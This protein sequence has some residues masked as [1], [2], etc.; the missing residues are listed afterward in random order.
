MSENDIEYEYEYEWDNYYC[1]PNSFVLKN[2]F[3][4]TDA[5]IL[6][7]AERRI[8][9]LNLLEMKD[10]PIRGKFDLKHLCKI[11]KAIF[12]DVFAWAG[13]L[14]TVDI[15]KGNQFCLSQN[16]EMY[17]ETVFNDLKKEEY[18]VGKT[19]EEMPERLTY[20]L[21]EIN[22]LHPFRDGNGRSQRVFIEYLARSVGY[23]VDFS[24]VTGKEMIEASALSFCKEYEMMLDM[25]KRITTKTTLQEQQM[26]RKQIGLV[27]EELER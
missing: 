22:V 25:F 24:D 9:S 12:G 18:L 6:S 5:N 15:S 1:Y 23:Y 11:H 26:F 21:S 20:Y 3:D 7:E 2:K 17:A 4:I 27:K 14:R 19:P 16:L 13:K 8:T 10:K